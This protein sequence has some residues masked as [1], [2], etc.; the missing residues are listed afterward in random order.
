MAGRTAGIGNL[1]VASFHLIRH[2]G[3][4]IDALTG[5]VWNF[6]IPNWARLLFS[7]YDLI[8]LNR[9]GQSIGTLLTIPDFWC[10]WFLRY[11]SRKSIVAYYRYL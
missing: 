3:G 6:S 9:R 1:Q 10:V 8:E 2:T 11:S 5:G 7:S 4:K